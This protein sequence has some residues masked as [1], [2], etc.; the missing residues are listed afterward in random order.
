MKIL[1]LGNNRV[2][3]EVARWLS[4]TGESIVGLVVHPPTRQKCASEIKSLLQ[5]PANAV[6]DAEQLRDPMTRESIAALGADIA[7]SVYFGFILRPEFLGL[8]AAGC[9]NLHPGLLPYNRGAHPNVWSIVEGTPA[10]VTL[11]YVDA[12]VDTG[13]LIAQAP[14]EVEPID[15]GASLYQKLEDASCSLFAQAWPGI[16]NGRASR[17][18]Q[19]TSTG[20]SHRVR[21]LKQ[22]D[23]IVL[24][25]EYTAR[26]LINRLRARTFPPFDGCYF[27]DK[28]RKVFANIELRYA[29]DE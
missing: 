17:Q 23:E 5:L 29:S 22:L 26:D 20:T 10:G 7:V 24:D 19:S 27:I 11:H 8:F 18:K 9:I 16:K 15:T 2:G 13:D 3:L 6:F 4:E 25:R 14:V 1:F 28:G 21:D 12:G